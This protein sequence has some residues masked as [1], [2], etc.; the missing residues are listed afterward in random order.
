MK[1]TASAIKVIASNAVKKAYTHDVLGF[2][3]CYWLH[4]GD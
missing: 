1:S 3:I 4:V 2:P